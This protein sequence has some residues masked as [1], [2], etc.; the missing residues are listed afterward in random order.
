MG[1]KVKRLHQVYISRE[2]KHHLEP[3]QIFLALW[4]TD[5]DRSSA[6][7]ESWTLSTALCMCFVSDDCLTQPPRT[8]SIEH[9]TGWPEWQ[10]IEVVLGTILREHS[11]SMRG[12]VQVSARQL[13]Y[14]ESKREQGGSRVPT[15]E[16]SKSEL[17]RFCRSMYSYKCSS[18]NPQDSCMMVA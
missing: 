17:S 7:S 4:L 3:N 16:E 9:I 10:G 15:E 13:D 1:C 2:S 14:V 5:W 11:I 12:N 8:M 6:G 18:T